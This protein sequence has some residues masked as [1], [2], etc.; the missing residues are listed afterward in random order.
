MTR[1]AGNDRA[2]RFRDATLPFLDDAYTLAHFYLGNQADAEDAVH[3]CYV[4]ALRDFDS[5]RS[6]AVRPRLLAILRN[7][8]HARLDR[9]ETSSAHAIAIGESSRPEPQATAQSAVPDTQSNVTIRQLIDAL[10]APLREIIVLRESSAMSYKEIAEVAGVP[11]SMVMSRLAQART[12]LLATRKAADSA[13]ADRI[14][15]G[16]VAVIDDQVRLRHRSRPRRDAEYT[17]GLRSHPST[18]LST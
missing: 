14:P 17:D 13:A 4:E 7:V 9:R 18:Y 5:F 16:H 1:K 12:Q 8:C 11:V 2:Q 10:P 3:E 15:G 6:P